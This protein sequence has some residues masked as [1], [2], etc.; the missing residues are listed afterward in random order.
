MELRGLL[1]N[2]SFPDANPFA[3][4]GTE[5]APAATA[6]SASLRDRRTFF[7]Q[8]PYA[9]TAMMFGSPSY[10]KYSFT[11][12]YGRHLSLGIGISSLEDAGTYGMSRLSLICIL[13]R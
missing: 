3:T 4:R 12:E 1:K 6:L 2:V 11:S 5:A 9:C 13:H 7:K 10:T 8:T